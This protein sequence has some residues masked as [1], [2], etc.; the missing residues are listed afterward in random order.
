MYNV[1]KRYE[2]IFKTIIDVHN[3]KNGWYSPDSYIQTL[4]T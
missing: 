2:Y 1:A 4:N 3:G